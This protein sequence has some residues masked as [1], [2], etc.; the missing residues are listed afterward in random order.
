MERELK[1]SEIKTIL[2]AYLFAG[3]T[4]DATEIARRIGVSVRT[5]DR[6]AETRLWQKTLTL[7]NYQGDRSLQKQA[8]R[9]PQR[10]KDTAEL[11]EQ[12][13]QIYNQL[14]AEGVPVH[15]RASTTAEKLGLERERVFRWAKRYHWNETE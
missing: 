4:Q 8:T 7:C 10:D 13:R 1:N 14:I 6:Y 15:K 9:D 2:A 12:A 5:I 3:G 11:V